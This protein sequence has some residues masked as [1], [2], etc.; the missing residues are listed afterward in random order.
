MAMLIFL[1]SVIISL[2]VVIIVVRN[3]CDLFQLK[4]GKYSSLTIKFKK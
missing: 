3:K 4:F 1:L 2:L